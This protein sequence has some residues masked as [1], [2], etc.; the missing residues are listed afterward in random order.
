VWVCGKETAAEIKEIPA[1]NN[2]HDN[3]GVKVQVLLS[4]TLS[5]RN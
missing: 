4:T 3:F 1:D 2:E 5:S